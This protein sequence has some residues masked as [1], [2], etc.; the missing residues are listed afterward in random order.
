M[1][2]P[3]LPGARGIAVLGPTGFVS[4]REQP[5]RLT[6]RCEYPD[7]SLPPTEVSLRLSRRYGI[8]DASDAHDWF[9]SMMGEHEE[10]E[11]ETD[12]PG[13]LPIPFC[14]NTV[15]WVRVE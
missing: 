3:P 13:E 7:T 10:F 14:V 15:K 6:I 1:L 8:L 11:V 12:E 2:L 5:P 4:E 9:L